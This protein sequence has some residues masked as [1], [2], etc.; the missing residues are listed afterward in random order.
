MK[1][2]LLM[3][4]LTVFFTSTCWGQKTD[5]PEVVL[6]PY[7]FS[8]P[9]T[10]NANKAL[11]DKLKRIVTKNGLSSSFENE[12]S[13]FILTANAIEQKK[14]VT[15]TVPPH[16]AVELSV[17]FYVGNGEDGTLF[18]S[19]NQ[20]VKG[21]GNNLD[22]AYA[23]AFRKINI[24]NPELTSTIEEGKKRIIS[25]YENSAPDLIAKAKSLAS[26]GN[27][28][29]AYALLLQI[30]SVCSQF[31]QAQEILTSLVAQESEQS[32]SSILASAR[33]A[34]SASPNETG[35]AEAKSLLAKMT[36]VSPKLQA[37]A[38]SLMKE[39]SSRLQKVED[40]EKAA[41]A[42]REANEHELAMEAVKG[43]TKV[44]VAQAKRPIYRIWWW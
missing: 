10:V 6:T 26:A 42:Q 30:P 34:W 8:N 18:G 32:N 29:E 35:A 25:Y 19:C 12:Q 13:P 15:A 4:A 7:V 36:N 21:V 38:T 40:N 23:A 3:I 1:K 31:S 20:E 33:A 27:Y 28:D 24:N 9:N 5:V 37:E 11:E 22:Q 43:A 39:I 2:N 17:T 41:Q 14:E 44:A 16:T